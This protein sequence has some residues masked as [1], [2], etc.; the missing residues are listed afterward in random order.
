[1][2]LPKCLTRAYKHNF[3]WISIFKGSA[4]VETDQNTYSLPSGMK[5]PLVTYF[6]FHFF[7][8]FTAF[9]LHKRKCS[10]LRLSNEFWLF[11]RVFLPT[12]WTEV[13]N[14]EWRTAWT[15]L[16]ESP[17]KRTQHGNNSFRRVRRYEMRISEIK[18]EECARP[19]SIDVDEVMETSNFFNEMV[20]SWVKDETWSWRG[21]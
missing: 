3:I 9:S 10:F 21:V 1:M 6:I 15:S 5:S 18:A 12:V 7:R 11:A 13:E 20:E 8:T 4:T 14:D 19:P 17:G 16:D 2:T